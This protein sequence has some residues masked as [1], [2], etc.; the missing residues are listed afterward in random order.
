M[1]ILP[2]LLFSC[3]GPEGLVV[4]GGC[5]G[6]CC[7]IIAVAGG[8]LLCVWFYFCRLGI[9]IAEFIIRIAC[10]IIHIMGWNKIVKLLFQQALYELIRD[11]ICSCSHVDLPCIS[12][13]EPLVNKSVCYR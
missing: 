12:C 3:G 5:Y 6:I 11:L 7:V 2:I 8:G 1:L 10:W 4:G 9:D 13:L